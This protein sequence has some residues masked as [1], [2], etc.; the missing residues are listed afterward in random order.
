MVLIEALDE[1]LPVADQD[2]QDALKFPGQ[3]LDMR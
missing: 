2:S 1:F 3:G